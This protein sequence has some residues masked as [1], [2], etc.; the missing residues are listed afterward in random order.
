MSKYIDV[1]EMKGKGKA[2]TIRYSVP[3]GCKRCIEEVFEEL[4]KTNQVG[5]KIHESNVA[6]MLIM[7]GYHEYRRVNPKER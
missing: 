2:T 5:K 6:A 3:E 4:P 7:L 1:H